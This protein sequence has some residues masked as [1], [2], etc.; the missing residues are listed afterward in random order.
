MIWYTC[1]GFNSSL[2]LSFPQRRLECQKQRV[3]KSSVFRF[4]LYTEDTGFSL[5]VWVMHRGQWRTYLRSYTKLF[6]SVLVRSTFL[7]EIL[8]WLSNA[9]AGARRVNGRF[10]DD[11]QAKSLWFSLAL[12]VGK[13]WVLVICLT[14][15]IPEEEHVLSEVVSPSMMMVPPPPS[16]NSKC[17]S[18]SRQSRQNEGPMMLAEGKTCDFQLYTFC[19]QNCIKDCPAIFGEKAIGVCTFNPPSCICRR[20]C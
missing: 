12:A 16:S 9:F 10:T 1:Q 18:P 19:D 14:E 7:I 2:R 6:L 20:P 3:A 15:E 17:L 11:N 5:Q 13:W 4:G 8:F